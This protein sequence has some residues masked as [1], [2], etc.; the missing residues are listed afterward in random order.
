MANLEV[1]PV[2]SDSIILIPLY[3]LQVLNK[4]CLNESM[5]ESSRVKMN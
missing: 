3:I 1:N 2:F 4:Y 5:N